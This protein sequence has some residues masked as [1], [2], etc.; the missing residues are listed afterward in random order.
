MQLCSE[1]DGVVKL[2]EVFERVLK[3]F[4]KRPELALYRRSRLF[5]FPPGSLALGEHLVGDISQN[6]PQQ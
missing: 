4:K 2:I 5:L 3:A 1:P 6:A